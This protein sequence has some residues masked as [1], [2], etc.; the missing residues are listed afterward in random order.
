MAVVVD[1]FG[2]TGGLVTLEDILEELV[3]EIWD[4]HDEVVESI[5]RQSDGSYPHRRQRR[6]QRPLR[7]FLHQGRQR[8][9]H[10]LRL[11]HRTAGPP[12]P[13]GATSSEGTGCLVTRVDHRRV[14]EIGWPG[15]EP[16]GRLRRPAT[17][18][19]CVPLEKRSFYASSTHRPMGAAVFLLLL[20][21]GMGVL[22]RLLA[23]GDA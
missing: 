18:A 12:A 13:A 16:G 2:G 14:L 4:E 17:A 9:Q 15:S 23:S 7:S 8:R 21:L 5:R 19:G 3:G 11:G 6:P 20:R 10:G 22:L 1:E